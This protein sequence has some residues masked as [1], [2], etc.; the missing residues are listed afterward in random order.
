MDKFGYDTKQSYHLL[1][2]IDQLEQMLT[3]NDIDLMRNKDECQSMRQGTWGN[4]EQLEEHFNKRMLALEELSLRVSLPQQPQ[5]GAMQSLLLK[6][7]EQ[8]YGSESKAQKNI[9][10]VSVKDMMDR[11]DRIE[12]KIDQKPYTPR[13]PG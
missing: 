11:L 2:L 6:C 9:E 10:Y 12:A 3:T 5:T 7:I 4:F 8:F 13:Y 1:R